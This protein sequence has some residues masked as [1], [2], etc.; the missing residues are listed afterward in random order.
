MESE[1]QYSA[2]IPI[3]ALD[4][5]TKR[6]LEAIAQRGP[7]PELPT[8][9]KALD[10]AIWGLHRTELTVIAARPGEG[11]T[12]LVLQI[13]NHLAR[14][15]KKVLFISLEM[16]AEQLVER[17]LVQLTHVDAWSLRTGA[18]V[19]AFAEKVELHREFI[20]NAGIKIVDSAGRVIPELKYILKE[21]E[22]KA[23][24]APDLLI[25][26][27]IQL[28]RSE[29][30]T[31]KNEAIGEYIQELKELAKRHNMA[32]LVTSQNNRD[33]KKQKEGRPKLENLK[34]SGAIEE[35]ADCVLML[36]W[37]ELGKEENPQGTKYWICVEK[38]RY[39]SPGQ[40]VPVKFESTQLTF[41][42]LEGE[43][44]TWP[45]GVALAEAEENDDDT[46]Q[47]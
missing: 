39:G 11:K 10:R 41:A 47:L 18:D 34:D 14:Q 6:V 42:D 32:V 8:G 23:G 15:G 28:T 7:T 21:I 46:I 29:N 19:G 20:N 2:D 35:L 16:T 5:L 38:Q 25:I 26:D 45:N 17:I 36:W 9:L 13:G 30:G 3:E 37:Q 40:M 24:G 22:E 44:G 4:D 1:P 43:V 33:A 12:T 27:F 31:P